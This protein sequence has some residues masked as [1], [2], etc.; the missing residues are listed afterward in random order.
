MRKWIATALAV[1][2]VVTLAIGGLVS[3][4]SL[5]SSKAA[6]QVKDINILSWT[7]SSSDWSTIL[8]QSIKTPNQK[9]LFMGVSLESG[10]YTRT[11]VKSKRNSEGDP[12]WDTSTA[13]A[14]IDVRVVVDEGTADERIAS[15]SDVVFNMREQTLSA[16][17][18]GIFTGDAIIVE[19]VP[20]DNDGDGLFNEDPVDEVDNDGDGLVDEDPEDYEHV[21]T[22]DYEL[23]EPEELELILDTMTANSFNFVMDQL[24]PGVHTVSVQARI[25][26]N[27]AAEEGEF[28]ARA[29]I[30]NGSLVI[31]VVRMIQGADWLI[32]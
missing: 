21:V 8:E 19:E 2:L 12:D 4:E 29:M 24:T 1:A 25:D 15:P 28:E 7:D 5:P 14:Q 3:A 6:A 18:M 31:E 17:F 26:V 16:K 13:H 30:G 20:V 9:D 10:L 27:G 23:L 11:L 22:I 32:D